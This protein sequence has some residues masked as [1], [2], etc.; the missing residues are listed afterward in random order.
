MWKTSDKRSQPYDQGGKKGAGKQRSNNGP[1]PSAAPGW[2]SDLVRNS[3]QCLAHVVTCPAVMQYI[4]DHEGIVCTLDQ[5]RV[6]LRAD[7]K[8]CCVVFFIQE[9]SKKISGVSQTPNCP[10]E[11]CNLTHKTLDIA[12]PEA[13]FTAPEIWNAPWPS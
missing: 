6:S 10:F 8:F 1:G 2:E 13:V 12:C 3:R 11:P 4:N 5:G 7:T 9:L